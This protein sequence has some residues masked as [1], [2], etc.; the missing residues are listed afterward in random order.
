M[1]GKDYNRADHLANERTFLSWIRTNLG[2]MA[3]GFVVQ[4]FALFM[5]QIEA[6]LGKTIIPNQPITP[7]PALHGYSSFVGISLVAT[8]AVLCIFAFFKFRKMERQISHDTPYKATYVL[9]TLLT[10]LVFAIGIFLIAY[11]IISRPVAH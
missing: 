1:A 11:L 8:G 4:K 7:A 5:Q 9:E 2:I 3:F 6:F 10:F